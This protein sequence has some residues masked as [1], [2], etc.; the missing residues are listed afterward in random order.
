MKNLVDHF[1]ALQ[2]SLPAQGPGFSALIQRDGH[3]LLELHHGLA[4]LELGVPLTAQSRYYLAS[5]SKQFTAAC[6]LDLVRQGAIGLDDD[7]TPH[8]PEV[9]QF[10]AAISVR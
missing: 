6:M 9:R 4:C 3:T 2:V 10:G 5:E 7:V 1:F 8:L